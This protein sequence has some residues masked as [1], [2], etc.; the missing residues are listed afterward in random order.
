MV[1]HKIM[2]FFD[3]F[4]YSLMC[5]FALIILIP[6]WSSIVMS[7]VSEGE[8]LSRGMYILYPKKLDLSSYISIL[9]SGSIIY[10]GYKITIFR[11][12]VGTACNLFVT[13]MLAYALS[14]RD[15]PWRKA[16]TFFVFFAMIFNGG[17]V[18]TFLIIKNTGLY[19]TLAAYIVPELVS[20]WN[21]F[22]M[23][24][25]FMLIPVELEE[26]A[27]IDGAS[28][29]VILVKV[30]LPLS[31]PVLLS[32]ALLYMAWHWNSWFDGLIYI[33]NRDLLTLQNVLR[34]T[35]IA[36]NLE[37]VYDIT[38]VSRPPLEA[39]RSA[40]IVVSTLPILCFFPFVQ[41]YFVKGILVGSIKG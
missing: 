25:F 20:A 8:R 28:P 22:L 18:L 11:V 41:K 38:A 17:L 36:A 29:P 35:L 39:V 26:A 16:I 10:S 2:T 40:M 34:N 3:F 31:V 9:K 4:N 13:T 21:L 15:L 14:K 7:L 6:I 12:T 23:R 5:I 24:N 30:F 19:N 32:I 33:R 1:K 37:D 27:I